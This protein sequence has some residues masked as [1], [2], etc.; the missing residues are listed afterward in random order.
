M[1]KEPFEEYKKRV[2]KIYNEEGYICAII[3]SNELYRTKKIKK[4][5]WRELYVY[6]KNELSEETE[7]NIKKRSK[8]NDM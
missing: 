2:K 8:K 6:L 5:E 4:E 3:Y 7:K 1:L